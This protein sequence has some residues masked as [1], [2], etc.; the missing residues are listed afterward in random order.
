M[1][2]ADV[3]DTAWQRA[4]GP[5]PRGFLTNRGEVTGLGALMC[6]DHQLKVLD[7]TPLVGKPTN[8]EAWD[9]YWA[10][11]APVNARSHRRDRGNR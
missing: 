1:L 4:L 8:I 6:D 10:F 2:A 3:T 7:E 11:C 5:A 9:G